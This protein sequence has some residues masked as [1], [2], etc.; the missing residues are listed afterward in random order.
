MKK[1][2]LKSL[3][4]FCAG[5]IALGAVSTSCGKF[6]EQL[7][8]QVTQLQGQ[9]DDLD[10]RLEEVEK[11]TAKLEALTL[12]VDALYTLQF[13]VNAENELL[14][15]FDG[16]QNWVSTGIVLVNK[17]DLLTEEDIPGLCPPCQYVPCDHECP[18]VALVDNGT[19]VTI[20]VGDAS[21]TIEK[22]MEV[23]FEVKGGRVFFTPGES[24]EINFNAVAIEEMFILGV[25]EGWAATIADGALQVSAPEADP[26]YYGWGSPV[27]GAQTGFIKVAAITADGKTLVGKASVCASLTGLAVYAY[28]GVAHFEVSGDFWDSYYYGVCKKDEFEATVTEALQAAYNWNTDYLE[29][30]GQNFESCEVPISHMLGTPDSPVEPEVGEEYIVWAFIDSYD[31]SYTLEEVVYTAYSVVD[32]DFEITEVQAFDVQIDLSVSGVDSYMA[33]S[34]PAESYIGPDSEYA[35]WGTSADNMIM[36]VQAGY[37]YGVVLTEDYT[38]SIYEIC[39]NTQF[40]ATGQAGLGKKCYLLVLPLDGRP[41]EAY[42]VEDVRTFETQCA[43]ATQGGDVTLA[44]QQVYEYDDWGEMVEVNRFNDI[45]LSL[46]PS[47]GWYAIY[48]VAMTDE[49]LAMYGAMD[50]LLIEYILDNSW[51]LYAFDQPAGTTSLT[52]PFTDLGQGNTINYVAIAVDANGQYTEIYKLQFSTDTVEYSTSLTLTATA[53]ENLTSNNVTITVETT[54]TA[55]KYRYVYFDESGS[56]WRYTYGGDPEAAMMALIT[57]DYSS[58]SNPSVNVDAADWDGTIEIEGLDYDKTYHFFVAAWDEVGL[59]QVAQCSFSP[60]FQIGTL[61]AKGTDEWAAAQPEIKYSFVEE[62]GYFPVT[63]D[64][65]PVEGTTV[66]IFINIPSEYEIDVTNN[67]GVVTALFNTL[68][69]YNSTH[70]TST[71]TVFG[72]YKFT[73]EDGDGFYSYTKDWINQ[74][75]RIVYAVKLADGTYCEPVV[76]NPYE[77]AATATVDGQWIIPAEYWGQIMGSYPALLDLGVSQPGYLLFAEDYETAYPDTP[78]TVGLWMQAGLPAGTY[79]IEA[80]DE[81]SGNVNFITVDFFGDEKIT[82]IPYSGLTATEC[83]FDF[84]NLIGTGAVTCTRAA[85]PITVTLGGGVM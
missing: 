79:T 7:T 72:Y 82:A 68:G 47:E 10:A 50:D 39:A 12:K 53:P 69:M 60:Q 62:D 80:T 21:F 33:V 17:D 11:L 19:S 57:N 58:W 22:P 81:T 85:E 3:M 74:D 1:T 76:I 20:T 14:Y 73:D 8:S 67:E 48:N 78:E 52:V 2:F 5:V 6:E 35:E 13:S 44:V 45:Y 49:E 42:T 25:P 16:G 15:S 77:A 61:V 51:G 18:Q 26:D 70:V 28:N 46:T 65:K 4:A 66:G 75:A 29:Q 37:D 30:F 36:N 40:S 43:P 41:M 64:L 63:V 32:I 54:G 38:G 24:K 56:T 27:L 55:T 31:S 71:G 59:P 84:S 83:T 9:I 34:L 23:E